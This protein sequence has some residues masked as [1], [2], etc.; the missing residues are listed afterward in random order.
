MVLLDSGLVYVVYFLYPVVSIVTEIVVVGAGRSDEVCSRHA[1]PD[2]TAGSPAQA[3][4]VH[5]EVPD[6]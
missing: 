3:E 6:L 4:Q 5:H 2:E 1:L